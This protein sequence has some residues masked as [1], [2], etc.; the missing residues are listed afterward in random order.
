[1]DPRIIESLRGRPEFEELRAFLRFKWV[2]FN[3]LSNLPELPDAHDLALEVKARL[4][5]VK[6]LEDVIGALA[7]V[8]VGPPPVSSREFIT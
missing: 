6:L 5:A 3:Q 8:K 7:D 4:R 2:E 1:M